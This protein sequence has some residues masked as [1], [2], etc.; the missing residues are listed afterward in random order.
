MKYQPDHE[1]DDKIAL[2]YLT[3]HSTYQVARRLH[4]TEGKVNR[5]LRRTNTP[6]RTISEAKKLRRLMV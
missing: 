5:S 6:R 4:L 1:M 3:G 2:L